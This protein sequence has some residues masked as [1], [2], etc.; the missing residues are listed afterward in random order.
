MPLRDPVAVYNAANNVEANLVKMALI[1][2]GVQVYV[3][4]D[5]PQV[6]VWALGLLPEINK[7]QVWVDKADI[8]LAR[9]VLEDYERRAMAR[10]RSEF[11][12]AQEEEGADEEEEADPDRTSPPTGMDTLRSMRRPLAWFFLLLLLSPLLVAALALLAWL[13]G[14]LLK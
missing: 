10:A 6:G 1:N 5:V 14:P 3:T 12:E 7:P 13:A 4:E 11:E 8:E 2:S 9:P